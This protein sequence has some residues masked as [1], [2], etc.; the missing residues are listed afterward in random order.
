MNVLQSTFFNDMP[1]FVFFAMGPPKQKVSKS[2]IKSFRHIATSANFIFSIP[3]FFTLF[4]SKE[5][6]HFT[7]ACFQRTVIFCR[8]LFFITIFHNSPSFHFLGTGS[9]P[10]LFHGWH[11]KILLIPS[12]APFK[13]PYFS[14]AS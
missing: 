7:I 1:H 4:R 6:S 3:S 8:F 5:G 13:N 12:H 9:Y 11:L 2:G 14:I 10:P